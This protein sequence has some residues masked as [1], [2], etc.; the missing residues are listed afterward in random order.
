MLVISVAV[1]DDRVEFSET[2]HGLKQFSPP[3]MPQAMSSAFLPQGTSNLADTPVV[4]YCGVLKSLGSQQANL[5]RKLFKAVATIIIGSHIVATILAVMALLSHRHDV[6]N[7][8]LPSFLGM[9]LVSLVVGFGIHQYL[10]HS[11]ACQVWAMS[12]LIAELARSVSAI[13]KQYLYLEYL[14]VLPF[15]SSLKPLLETLCVLHMRSTRGDTTAWQLKRDVYVV[16]RLTAPDAQI[17]YYAK[18]ADRAKMWLRIWHTTFVTC[19]LAA[20]ISTSLKLWV[21]AYVDE[22]YRDTL[23]AL[24]GALAIVL[25][26]LAVGALSLAA[27]LD[28]EAREHTY[29]EIRAF[30][31]EQE[32]H[33][34]EVTL[35]RDFARLVLETESQLLGETANWFSRRSFTGVA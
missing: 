2:C 26:L 21:I 35:E 17:D 24:L 29:D 30:L 8:L 18:S 12:R 6:P 7:W 3:E 19:S 23:T 34:K 1:K 20:V 9:E 14:F 5:Q 22:D 13:G 25:P 27:A 11:R 31:R 33:L 15:P 4:E 16:K 10:H 32:R 28:L